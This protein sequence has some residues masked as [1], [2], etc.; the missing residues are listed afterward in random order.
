MKKEFDPSFI[1]Q[2][3]IKRLQDLGYKYNKGMDYIFLTIYFL[4]EEGKD[5]DW[6]FMRI[7]DN[8]H[9][10]AN[11][12][13]LP[14]ASYKR[15]E[16]SDF[17]SYSHISFLEDMD[18]SEID[19]ITISGKGETKLFDSWEELTIWMGVEGEKAKL[20]VL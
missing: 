1:S 17:S 15:W 12:D 3:V 11:N 14:K 8:P 6:V 18:K 13:S 2:S 16:C 7:E 4:P 20:F 19:H 9:L 10:K 5:G